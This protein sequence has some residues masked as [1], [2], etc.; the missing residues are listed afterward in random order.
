MKTGY[1]RNLRMCLEYSYVTLGSWV[2]CRRHGDML[3]F[4]GRE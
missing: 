3:P 4:L 1:I 2:C